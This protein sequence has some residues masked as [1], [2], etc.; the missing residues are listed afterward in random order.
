MVQIIVFPIHIATTED[1]VYYP[2][3]PSI[4]LIP[5]NFGTC[6]LSNLRFC[7]ENIYGN[8]LLTVPFGFGI[9]LLARFKPRRIFWIAVL[10][11]L[12]L[13]GTQ[14]T[15]SLLFKSAFRTIDINDVILNGTG[16]L[17]GYGLFVGFSKIYL[18]ALKKFSLNP[19]GIFGYLQ[20]IGLQHTL[21]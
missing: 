2:F 19:T 20:E 7:L 8:L 14:L 18:T 6:T 3:S 21:T 9:P 10:T 15:L 13:E 4:N 17:L 5:F 11:G 16:V 1:L 12:T